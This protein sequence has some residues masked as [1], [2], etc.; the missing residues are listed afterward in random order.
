M[1]S[2][3]SALANARRLLAQD[4]LL[5]GEQAAEILKV[6]PRHPVATLLLGV[7]RRLAGDAKAAVTVLE[8]LV[9]DQPRSAAAAFEL[10]AALTEL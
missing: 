1:G 9:A 7:A 8:A 10:G 4:P 6:V 2:L 3:E 5:A